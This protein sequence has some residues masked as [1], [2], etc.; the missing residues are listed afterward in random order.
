MLTWQEILLFSMV[1]EVSDD[2]AIWQRGCGGPDLDDHMGN[3]SVT[4]LRPMHF[5]PIPT[6]PFLSRKTSFDIL[7]RGN[8]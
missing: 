5:L 4:S 6:G 1:V 3:I 7:R 2:F 8:E